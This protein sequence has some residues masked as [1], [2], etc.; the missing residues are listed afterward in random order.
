MV[1][2]LASHVSKHQTFIAGLALRD[3]MS[4]RQSLMPTMIKHWSPFSNLNLNSQ[5]LEIKKNFWETFW[6]KSV[7]QKHLGFKSSA[8]RVR[9]F[10]TYHVGFETYA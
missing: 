10:E 4:R 6:I 1:S 8:D 9:G 3:S 7:K 5:R 2:K